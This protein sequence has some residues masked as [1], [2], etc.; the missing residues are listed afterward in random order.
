[1]KEGSSQYG[2]DDGMKRSNSCCG[3]VRLLVGGEVGSTSW[4][5]L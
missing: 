1:M 4:Q 3:N 2:V 5:E